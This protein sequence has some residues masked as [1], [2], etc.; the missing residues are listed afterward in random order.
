MQLE[1]AEK[2][3]SY[4]R[5]R[6]VSFHLPARTRSMP[7]REPI[8]KIVDTSDGTFLAC[9]Q[10]GLMTF[11]SSQIE[12]KRSKSVV[13]AVSF[14]FFPPACSVIRGRRNGHRWFFSIVFCHPPS[15]FPVPQF[16]G[17]YPQHPSTLSSIFLFF[18]I[19]SCLLVLSACAGMFKL[20]SFSIP[21][22]IHSTFCQF[23][24][25][26]ICLFQLSYSFFT[27]DQIILKYVDI[28][29]DLSFLMRIFPNFFVVS[30]Q[31]DL[32]S[33]SPN[34]RFYLKSWLVLSIHL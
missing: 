30:E 29:D 25:C 15:F 18:R 6:E 12:I 22:P 7:H 32:V 11:W 1:Y 13:T 26:K 19:V 21:K 3:D 5:S 17:L 33:S 23:H 20:A 10:D 14:L 31:P 16:S 34:N 27:H 8:L 2:E 9:S 4:L 24:S 28:L